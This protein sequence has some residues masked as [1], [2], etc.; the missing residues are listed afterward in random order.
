MKVAKSKAVI[1][2]VAVAFVSVFFFAYAVQ[3]VYLA[4][5]YSDFCGEEFKASSDNSVDCEADGGKWNDYGQKI[6]PVEG[7]EI[8]IREGWCEAD[9]VCRGEYND[10]RNIYER[11]VFFVNFII[12]LVVLVVAF[13]LTLEAVSSGLMGGAVMLIIYGSMRYWGELSDIWRTLMLGVALAVLIW[14]GYRK[15]RD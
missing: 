15:L 12:G 14:L 13:F 1:F 9:F 10:E 6:R 5:E 2:S 4:P 3:A 8:V 7:E 11:N